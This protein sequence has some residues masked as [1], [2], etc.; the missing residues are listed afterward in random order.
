MKRDS[1]KLL[2]PYAVAVLAVA[3][4]IIMRFLI[5]PFLGNHVPFITFF[6]AI[7][8]ASFYGGFWRGIGATVLG[9]FAAWYFF[10]PMRFSFAG[11]SEPYMFGLVTYL[12]VGLTIS[13]FGEMM[14][15]AQHRCK[16]SEQ[17]YKTLTSHAPVGIF[18]TDA[19][20]NCLLVNERWC[21]MAGLSP[22]KAQGQG[23]VNALHPEDRDY[24][25]REWYEAAETER[26]FRSEYRFRTPQGKVTWLSGSAI[27]LRQEDRKI[28]G[29]IGTVTDITVRKHAEEALKEADRRKDEFLA[30]LAHELR[31]PLAPIS[32]ALH[33]LRSPSINAQIQREALNMADHQVKQM[34]RL[35]DDLLDVS[36][37]THGKITIQQEW[38]DLC[39]VL[40][41]AV[42]TA[43]PLIDE[44]QHHLQIKLPEC[45]MW[46]NGDAARLTQ[47]FGNLLNNA[48][49]YT[50]N[51]GEITLEATQSDSVAVISIRDNGIG[52]ALDKLPHIF[53]I[54]VQVDN[55]L[56]RSQ[57]GLGIG[58]ML[59]KSIAELHGGSVEVHSD[60]EGKGTDFVVKL[61]LIEPKL[62]IMG[63]KESAKLTPSHDSYRMLVVD[64]NQAS[65]KTL[66]WM[67]E[68]L[69]HQV[70]IVYRAKDALDIAKKNALDVIFLDIGM[71]DM[72][73]FE[74]C[75]RLHKEPGL[76]DTVFIAQSGWGQEE[77]LQQS[78][79]SGFDYHLIKPISIDALQKQLEVVKKTQLVTEN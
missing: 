54:F 35:L 55:S 6:L 29:Y 10:I 60:G 1:R 32:N 18:E 26:E 67:L 68:A 76:K 75:R 58:L 4:A 8:V 62:N 27:A 56:R 65:A 39:Q 59:V 15:R 50:N 21:E 66:G 61:P 12:L 11:I 64:D 69:G 70:E 36:R 24:V 28:T 23:W 48:A 38:T 33:I 41:D 20:G 74:L 51:G 19:E 52:I 13:A 63:E 2:L 16:L 14:H 5:D 77:H 49:K 42:D 30:M 7:V 71:P 17:R 25:R 46:I 31:N 79:E 47:L 45:P 9:F 53:D 34:A 3:A 72:D 22:E 37:I 44:R 78:K 40:Q 43:K 73:G 57:G